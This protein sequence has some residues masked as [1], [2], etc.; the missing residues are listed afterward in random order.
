MVFGPHACH[1]VCCAASREGGPAGK[2]VPNFW[3]KRA[4]LG[5]PSGAKQR[6]A[7]ILLAMLT[8]TLVASFAAA[9]LWQQWRSVEVES[10]ERARVQASWILTGALDWARLILREDARSGAQGSPP[11]DHLGEPW[12]V[13]LEEARLS[14][15][16]AA[17]SNGVAT[18]DDQTERAFLSGS[19]EDMQGRLNVRN[20]IGSDRA[21][22]DAVA[23]KQFFK[24]FDLLGLPQGE[25]ESLAENLRLA[26]E[27]STNSQSTAG[28][29]LLPTRMSHLAWLGLSARTLAVLEPF[30][31]V[32]PNSVVG[33]RSAGAAPTPLAIRTPLNINT[34]S[35]E[36]LFAAIDGLDLADA[37]RIVSIRAQ[38]HFQKIT[39]LDQVVT[40]L[41]TKIAGLNTQDA[42]V[43]LY[44]VNSSFFEVLGRL[45][46]DQAT[47]QERSLVSRQGVEVTTQWRE[48]GVVDPALS[49][50]RQ[51]GP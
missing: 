24:L 37:K 40:G 16:L 7:A 2:P 38:A 1:C 30:V 31:F 5:R 26:S 48:R 45:R 47:V 15:F 4:R 50:P 32:P 41:G 21:V 19:I 28:A 33:P 43:R 39:D 8:V 22:I 36:V 46:L 11:V 29:P 10:A 35:E 49:K 13:P 42:A 17:D 18:V 23:F 20:L 34:A 6:G 9:A 25:L 51:P 44:S 14:T 3:S 12:A 27:P